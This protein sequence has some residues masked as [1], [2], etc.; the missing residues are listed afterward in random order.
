MFS[1]LGTEKAELA[2]G[3]TATRVRGEEIN[4]LNYWRIKI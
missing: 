4:P 1:F 2:L 3:I